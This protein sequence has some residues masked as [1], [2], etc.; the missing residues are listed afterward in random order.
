MFERKMKGLVLVAFSLLLL[1]IL[2]ACGD[3]TPN[4]ASTNA[5]P[6]A[7][8]VVSGTTK[9]KVAKGGT[10]GSQ[11]VNGASCPFFTQ[12][13][14]TSVFGTSP[15]QQ[16]FSD[17]AI[18]L[19]CHYENDNS[20]SKLYILTVDKLKEERTQPQFQSDKV[21]NQELA[22]AQIEDIAGLGDAAYRYAS[23]IVYVLKGKTVFQFTFTS[24]VG[25]SEAE[26][27]NKFKAIAQKVL[28][29]I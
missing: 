27:L 5:N 22:G 1:A 24:N 10:T 3:E 25:L 23:D 20:S 11:I 6:A 21:R 16:Q 15:A 2:T 14:F 29:H 8:T 12:E 28:K 13:D 26:K 19:R 17:E 4:S 9:S 18:S 7:S